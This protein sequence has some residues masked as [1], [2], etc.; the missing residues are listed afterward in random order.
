MKVTL[1]DLQ[2]YIAENG[3]IDYYQNG[4][5]QSGLKPSAAL[6][7]YNSLIKNYSATV[8]S[9]CFYLPPMK[10]QS[11]TAASTIPAVNIEAERRAEE[12]RRRRVK[13]ETD[14][15]IEYQKWQ[16]EQEAQG[17][18]SIMSFARWK[19]QQGKEMKK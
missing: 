13:K 3:V 10:K 9:L 16:R 11:F 7:S 4:A 18:K 19:E 15:A 5:N 6:Q 8:K 14:L 2:E 17:N 12:E 1:D